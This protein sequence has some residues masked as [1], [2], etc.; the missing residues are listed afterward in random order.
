LDDVMSW[1]D[2]TGRAGA[3]AHRAEEFWRI[4]IRPWCIRAD[5][6]RAHYC[7][8]GLSPSFFGEMRALDRGLM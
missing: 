4:R 3:R 8:P 6:A 1:V 7:D 2:E 5:G